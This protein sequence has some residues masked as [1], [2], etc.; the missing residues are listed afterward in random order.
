MSK[1][2][3]AF[4]PIE[5][6]D[7]DSLDKSCDSNTE[8]YA[9]FKMTE[10]QYDHPI[11][12]LF[13]NRENMK[14]KKMSLNHSYKIYDCQHVYPT[15]QPTNL[16]KKNIFTKFA[17]L[18]DPL[19]FLIGKYKGSYDAIREL[20]ISEK[21]HEKL[22]SIHNASYVDN[23]FCYLSGQLLSHHHVVHGL[24]YYGSVLGIQD[25]Y[26]MNIAD[27][28]DYL[29]ESPHFIENKGKLYELDEGEIEGEEHPVFFEGSS[30]ANRGKLNIHNNTAISTISLGQEIE[31]EDIGSQDTLQEIEIGGLEGEHD[32]IKLDDLCGE[33][34]D[35]DSELNY[36]ED[37]CESECESEGNR[38]KDDNEDEWE[39][40]DEDE[41][42]DEESSEFEPDPILNAYFYNFPVQMIC[43]EKCH[44][45]LDDLF[46]KKI[47]D[48]DTAASAL[49]QIIMTLIIYQKV[50]HFTHNDLHTQNIMYIETDIEYLYYTYKKKTY[51][52]PTHGR[53]FK[54]I[55]FGRAIY[56]FQ[57]NLFCSDSFAPGGDGHTQYNCEP[58]L[59]DKK[60]RIDPNYAFDICRLGCSIY[61]YILDI[62]DEMDTKVEKNPLEETIIRWVSD[63]Q[64]KNVLYKK[65]GEERYPNFKL[66]KMIAR[67]VHR[68]LPEEQ[69]KDPFFSQFECKKKEV[70][71]NSVIDID[72]LPVYV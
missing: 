69:L 62:D 41:D 55:D 50:Y 44:G 56:K 3:I 53:I 5:H 47:L 72:V 58:F 21:S 52:V 16:V 45:T 63:D 11:Y 12:W 46:S 57:G 60:P 32:E 38:K 42:E 59:D 70:K 27:D 9:P 26:K 4:D 10:L 6:L 2:S 24:E 66:Y 51:R 48:I 29:M 34:D 67:T 40:V 64:G 68:H 13:E 18:V 37:E 17:P 30:R 25:K 19:K 35:E 23:F 36:S 54:I 61:D 71:G 8:H 1:Y 28:Y 15:G 33:D 49:F 43:L 7:L 22:I 39:S 65:S 20:P 31:V 14:T